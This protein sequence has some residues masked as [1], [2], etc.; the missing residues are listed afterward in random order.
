MRHGFSSTAWTPDRER[1][2]LP[3]PY[4]TPGPA[5][6]TAAHQTNHRMGCRP[7]WWKSE[8]LDA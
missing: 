7:K 3:P 1:K 4:E 6:A 5:A 2:L 8:L